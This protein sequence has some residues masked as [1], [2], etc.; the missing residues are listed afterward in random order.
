[1]EEGDPVYVPRVG[2]MRLEDP[3]GFFEYFAEMVKRAC[4]DAEREAERRYAGRIAKL[5]AEKKAADR[6]TLYALEEQRRA[7]RRHEAFRAE[8][9]ADMLAVQEEMDRMKN[10]YE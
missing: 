4:R 7:E 1:M 10:Q 3:E 9:E 5:K 6:L 2:P 8:I